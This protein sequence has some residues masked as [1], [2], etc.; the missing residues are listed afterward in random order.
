MAIC[1]STSTLSSAWQQRPSHASRQPWRAVA[2]AP[3]RALRRSVKTAASATD[4][5]VFAGR[6]G[7]WSIEPED[8]AEVWGYR[9][10]ISVAAAATLATSCLAVA[11]E[12]SDLRSWL[13]T[14]ADPLCCTG[15]AALGVSLQLIHI[16]LAPLKRALQVLWL[17]G[18]CGGAYLMAT[19]E[20]PVAL[21]VAQHPAAVWLVGP[22]WAS[23]TG[24]AFKEGL[25]Y[26]KLEAA[27]LFGTVPLWLL[28]HLGQVVP[29]EGERGLL[30]VVVGTLAVFAARKYTQP[31]KDDIGD[32]SV[33][34]FMSLTAEEQEALLQEYKQ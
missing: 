13:L 19:Q 21:Y 33:F 4:K 34:K 2:C 18:C 14:L 31:I 32:K 7:A 30:A 20:P 10:G 23:L 25:C 8:V 1:C 28:C 27:L 3:L 11:P 26:G 6:F 29:P 22:L 16:Y 5:E 15:A 24:V 9:V 17:L 12:G